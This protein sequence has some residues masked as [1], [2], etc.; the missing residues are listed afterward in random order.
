MLI[1]T[2]NPENLGFR[3]ALKPHPA[4]KQSKIGLFILQYI[5]EVIDRPGQ[6]VASLL[7][8]LCDTMLFEEVVPVLLNKEREPS[9]PP[10]ES[11]DLNKER[12]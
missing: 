11:R 6:T 5:R 2:Y 1:A 3:T 8:G 4:K 9:V 12:S 10:D 7:L